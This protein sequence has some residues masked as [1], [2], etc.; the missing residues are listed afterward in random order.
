[1]VG[2]TSILDEFLNHVNPNGYFFTCNAIGLCRFVFFDSV[3]RKAF[4][5]CCWRGW[6]YLGCVSRPLGTC[7]RLTLQQESI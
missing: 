5:P 1:M 7:K 3:D 2:F 6:Q 4:E